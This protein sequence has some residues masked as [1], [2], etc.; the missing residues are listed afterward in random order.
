MGKKRKQGTCQSKPL[1]NTS[2]YWKD[3]VRI[4]LYGK[5]TSCHLSR[6]SRFPYKSL[7]TAKF[8]NRHNISLCITGLNSIWAFKCVRERLNDNLKISH[9]VACERQTSLLHAHRRWRRFREEES[10]VCDSCS[11]WVLLELV[12]R[13]TQHFTNVDQEKRK[14]EQ[15][16]N[17]EPHDYRIYYVNIGLRHQYGISVAD[18]RW[19]A[20]RNVCRSQATHKDL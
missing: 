20:R 14:I 11:I 2:L 8:S 16:L 10:N 1:V 18:Q 13:S 5:N 4:D 6:L 15:N 7:W 9:K 17:L 3:C 12:R 19:W